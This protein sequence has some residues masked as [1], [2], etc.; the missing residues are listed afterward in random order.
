VS[1]SQGGLLALRARAGAPAEQ[2]ADRHEL[3][4][5]SSHR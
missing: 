4:S 5:A 3:D 2:Q 1:P